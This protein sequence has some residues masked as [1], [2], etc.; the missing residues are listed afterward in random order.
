MA[1]GGV[2]LEALGAPLT[3][4][5]PH[6]GPRGAN[7]ACVVKETR[8]ARRTAASVATP[9]IMPLDLVAWALYRRGRSAEE[10]AAQTGLDREQ[11]VE[12][13]IRGFRLTLEEG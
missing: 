12:A 11:A 3:L 7:C 13:I 9:Q 4:V 2:I 10:V 6:R 5:D 1:F 8:A